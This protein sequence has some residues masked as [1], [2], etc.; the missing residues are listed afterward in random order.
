[1]IND[2]VINKEKVLIKI[3][4]SKV[5]IMYKLKKTKKM[6]LTIMQML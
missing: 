2:Y 3:V 1:M 5:K 4:K 6:I